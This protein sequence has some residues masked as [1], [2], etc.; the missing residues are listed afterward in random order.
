MKGSAF[1]G[2]MRVGA[3]L[4]FCD[5]RSVVKGLGPEVKHEPDSGSHTN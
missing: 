2:M 4:G 1:K 3:N 5:G